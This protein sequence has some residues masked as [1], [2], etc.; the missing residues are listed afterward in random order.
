MLDAVVIGGG[1]G[2]SAAAAFLARRGHSVLLLERNCFPRFHIGESQLPWISEALAEIGATD[3]VE[4]AGFIEKWGASFLNGNSGVERYADFECAPEVPTPRTYQV[5]REKFDQI[6]LTHAEECGVDVRQGCQVIAVSFDT[7]GVTVTYT[8]P[9][10]YE[11][12]V[13]ALVVIDASGRKGFLARRFGERRLDPVL[14]NIAVYRR[15][16]RILRQDGRRAGDIRIV[17][18]QDGGWFW[19]IPISRSV[20]SVGVVLPRRVYQAMARSTPDE[21]FDALV[22]STP[23]ANILLAP[24]RPLTAARVESDYS[25]LHSC[26][27]GDRFVLVGDAGSFLDPIFSTGVLFAMQSGIE[28]GQAV[29]DGLHVGDLRACKFRGFERRVV[30]R[31]RYFRR[32]AV[33][34]YDPAFRALFLSPSSRF[35]MYE[36]V[37]SVLAGNW[38]PSLATRVRL[39]LFFILVAVQRVFPLVPNQEVDDV[40]RV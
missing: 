1:P 22:A 18:R 4:N 38:R 40:G 26:Q 16:D 3:V 8:A 25:Y 36:A 14:R 27:A 12:T 13:R 39:W 15:H 32:F 33:G 30:R 35:G 23:T 5:D 7:S 31:Y 10:G 20:M 19:F 2:G 24:S 29:S 17:T 37:L 21:T 11:R 6:L 28:A 9:A 34:F